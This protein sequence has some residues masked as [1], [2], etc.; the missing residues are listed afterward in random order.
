MKAGNR[1]EQY[2]PN[3]SNVPDDSGTYRFA[4]MNTPYAA[5]NLRQTNGIAATNSSAVTPYK[6][7]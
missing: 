7:S 5:P 4:S 6:V 3:P 1:T 2:R